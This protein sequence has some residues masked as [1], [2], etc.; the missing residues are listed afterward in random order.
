MPKRNIKSIDLKKKNLMWHMCDILIL[1]SY[2][3]YVNNIIYI[4]W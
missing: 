2:F 3:Y 4:L 1:N